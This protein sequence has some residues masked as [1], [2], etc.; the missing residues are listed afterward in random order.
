ML[1]WSKPLYDRDGDDVEVIDVSMTRPKTERVKVK[2][3]NPNIR[4]G[5]IHQFVPHFF[6]DENGKHH[7]SDPAKCV[8]SITNSCNKKSDAEKTPETMAAAALATLE[9]QQREKVQAAIDEFKSLTPPGMIVFMLVLRGSL[10]EI[11]RQ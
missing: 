4:R 2:W 7:C 9:P 10:E 8:L 5:I 6:V 1:D 3:K 11:T